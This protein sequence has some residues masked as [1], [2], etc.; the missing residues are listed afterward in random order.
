MASTGTN[1]LLLPTVP[2][3]MSTYSSIATFRRKVAFGSPSNTLSRKG[4]G[5]PEQ[6]SVRLFGWEE[7]V[8]PIVE[9]LKAVAP[10]TTII[11][12]Q[13]AADKRFTDALKANAELHNAADKRFAESRDAADKRFAEA[14]KSSSEIRGA[15]KET[16]DAIVSK[17]SAEIAAALKA[18]A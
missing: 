10:L 2:K 7:T 6:R 9:L 8:P 18:K 5:Q 4:F 16:L 1:A 3:P 12:Y 11:I 13:Y 14:L 15:D 17:L